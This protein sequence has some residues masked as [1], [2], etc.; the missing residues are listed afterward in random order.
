MPADPPPAKNPQAHTLLPLPHHCLPPQHAPQGTPA[1]FPCGKNVKPAMTSPKASQAFPFPAFM[2]FHTSAGK[3]PNITLWSFLHN[4][5]KSPLHKKLHFRH[6]PKKAFA[7]GDFDTTPPRMTLLR[8]L[9]GI[10]WCQ[11]AALERRSTPS[12]PKGATSLFVYLYIAPRWAC[13]FWFAAHLCLHSVPDSQIRIGPTA[14]KSHPYLICE[15]SIGTFS[16]LNPE[17]EPTLPKCF[18]DSTLPEKNQKGY[19]YA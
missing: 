3:G 12:A 10:F 6:T 2:R 16:I 17:K 11:G 18:F 13:C 1:F 19:V 5:Y 9:S 15:S 14:G 7:I 4:F 8:S